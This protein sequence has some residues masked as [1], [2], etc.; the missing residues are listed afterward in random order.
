MELCWEAKGWWPSA[1]ASVDKCLTGQ[2]SRATRDGLC[3]PLLVQLV[4]NQLLLAPACRPLLRYPEASYL[5]PQGSG[6]RAGRGHLSVRAEMMAG[7]PVGVAGASAHWVWV[8][9]PACMHFLG[10]TS[11]MGG[12]GGVGNLSTKVPLSLSLR[13]T[14]QDFSSGVC[15]RIP[16]FICVL[17]LHCFLFPFAAPFC[18]FFF[19]LCADLGLWSSNILWGQK[20]VP[21]HL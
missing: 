8:W 18:L 17:L 9:G 15:A 14:L 21:C 2:S 19:P 7:L 6:G 10:G 13:T 20:L 4:Q 3:C 12:D 16:K 1:W 5:D 11:E